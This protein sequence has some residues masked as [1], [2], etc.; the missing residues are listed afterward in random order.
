MRHLVVMDTE[1]TKLWLEVD[2]CML[3]ETQLLLRRFHD[4]KV[5]G[6]VAFEEHERRTLPCSR[7]ELCQRFLDS[8]V[9]KDFL[10]RKGKQPLHI[11]F[12]Q[13]RVCSCM[14]DE[15]MTQCAD[16]IDTQF[17]ILFKAWLKAMPGWFDDDE[18]DI[19]NC[20]CKELG[21]FEIETTKHLWAFLFR[22]TCAP[23]PDPTR[24][25]ARDVGEHTQ[26]AHDCVSNLCDDFACDVW[27][28]NSKAAQTPLG[29]IGVAMYVAGSI[30]RNGRRARY[31]RGRSEGR[32]CAHI[33][34]VV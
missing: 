28:P 24:A 5:E 30:L 18:C 9:Y 29:S 21:F 22:D 4:E 16:S 33:T 19:D 11:S 8:N 7:V 23:K 17:N 15:K 2:D 12:F 20:V 1:I 14:V 34:R 27:Y 6:K 31:S 32:M 10:E 13:H 25:L 3:V 26:L